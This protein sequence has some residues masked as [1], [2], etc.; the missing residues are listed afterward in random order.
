VTIA[1]NDSSGGGGGGTTS[2]G[3][4]GGAIDWLLVVVGLTC[5]LLQVRRGDHVFTRIRPCAVRDA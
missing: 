2:S 3:G 4:G 1:D 5:T